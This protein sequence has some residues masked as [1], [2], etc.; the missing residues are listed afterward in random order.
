M[1][2]VSQD[3]AQYI[4]SKEYIDT[5][6]VPLVPVSLGDKMPQ[7]AS[8]SEFIGILA[9]GLERQFA[10]RALLL[11]SFTYLHTENRQEIEVRLKRWETGLEEEGLRHIFFVTSDQV[12]IQSNDAL[13]G[14]LLWLPS[15]PLSSM[16]DQ[17][18]KTLINEQVKQ[19]SELFTS[20]W[21][22]EK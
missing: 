22:E 8:M 16:D 15:L 4:Q 21:R 7:S 13:A 14:T 18:K 1:K 2:W 20:K 3:I 11:P 19:L 5:A 17:Q 6:I 9:L 10:G 12:W